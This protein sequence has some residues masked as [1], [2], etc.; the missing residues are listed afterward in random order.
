[1]FKILNVE[2]IH[3]KILMNIDQYGIHP[4]FLNEIIGTSSNNDFNMGESENIFNIF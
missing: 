1:M 4:K 2:I 3:V